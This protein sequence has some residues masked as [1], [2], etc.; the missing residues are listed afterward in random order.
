[1]TVRTITRTDHQHRLDILRRLVIGSPDAC[2][3]LYQACDGSAAEV[4]MAMDS[5]EKLCAAFRDGT[6]LTRHDVVQLL[7]GAVE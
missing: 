7:S 4:T 5:Y 3:S 6:N 2:H 1:M